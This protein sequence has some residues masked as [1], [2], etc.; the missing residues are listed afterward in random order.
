MNEQTNEMDSNSQTNEPEEWEEFEEEYLVLAEVE[1]F[2]PHN[3]Q[4]RDSRQRCCCALL[5]RCFETF[6]TNKTPTKHH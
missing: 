6:D 4:Q 5:V 2:D 3:I 1:G